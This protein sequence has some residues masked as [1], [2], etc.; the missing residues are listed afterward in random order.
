MRISLP[1]RRFRNACRHLIC[2]GLLPAILFITSFAGNS[3]RQN[4]DPLA[5]LVR[6]AVENELE[7]YSQQTTNWK[8][9]SQV[10]EPDSSRTEVVVETPYGILSRPLLLKG[11]PLTPKQNQQEDRRIWNLVHNPRELD[12]QNADRKDDWDTAFGLL[13]MVPDGLLFTR[14][15]EDEQTVRLSFQT[16]PD[17]SAPTWESRVFYAAQGY[18]KLDKKQK[19][20][21]EMKGRL[22]DDVEFG[23]GLLGKLHKG[24]TVELKQE[25]IER[26]NWE[27]TLLDIQITGK[28]WFFKT[29]GKQRQEICSSFQRVPDNITLE[30]AAEIMSRE[31]LPPKK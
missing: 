25:Q 22:S 31:V 10:R 15:S 12:K 11:L 7:A 2:C 9:I 8:Y 28:A 6:Q 17:F 30:R 3:R 20:F 29:F 1:H 14:D 27:V 19:R 13:K 16:N 24:G 18:L 4:P 21:I 5:D 23:W 26:G